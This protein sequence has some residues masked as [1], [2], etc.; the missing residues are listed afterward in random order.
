MATTAGRVITFL[1]ILLMTGL[2]ACGSSPATGTGGVVGAVETISY[3]TAVAGNATGTAEASRAIATGTAEAS[4]VYATGTAVMTT[5]TAAAASTATA[6]ANVSAT[7]VMATETAVAPTR[8]E[9]TRIAVVKA[10]R[11]NIQTGML[12]DSAEA[13]AELNAQ[14]LAHNQALIALDLERRAAEQRYE[15][16]KHYVS[17]V[18]GGLV[19]LVLVIIVSLVVGTWIMA[20]AADRKA[21]RDL[22]R[23]GLL[24]DGQRSAPA[25]SDDNT[26]EGALS[27]A[28]PASAN[29]GQITV[30]ESHDLLRGRR[31]NW[32]MFTEWRERYHIPLGAG[33]DGPVTLNVLESPH[34]AIVGSSR[35]GKSTGG[36]LTVGAWHLSHG[37]H[38]L[39]LNERAS[40]FRPFYTHPNAVHLRAYSLDARMALAQ[41]AVEAMLREME[42]R[43]NVL[44]RAGFNTWHQIVESG[45]LARNPEFGGEHGG[46]VIVIDEF[47]SMMAASST[48]T[49]DAFMTALVHLTAEAGKFDISAVV[50]ATDP[51]REALGRYGYTAMQQ[52]ARMVFGFHGDGPSLSILGNKSAVNLPVGHFI[53]ESE[54]GRPQAGVAFRPSGDD[55]A[56][57]LRRWPVGYRPTPGCL[58]P[59]LTATADTP[60]PRS[61]EPDEF[62]RAAGL[63]YTRGVVEDARLVMQYADSALQTR[64]AIARKLAADGH[65]GWGSSGENVRRVELAL[66]YLSRARNV[67]WAADILKEAP[68]SSLGVAGREQAVVLDFAGAAAD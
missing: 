62:A 19:V 11:D 3:A 55:L 10:E 1:S 26:I 45:E 22:L 44:H 13:Q 64:T 38:V 23:R 33:V 14:A 42:R 30:L 48:A 36:L 50:A 2:A 46:L 21:R 43:D 7:A 24:T 51:R 17:L 29:R 59:L 39:F 41:G 40:N 65:V 25:Q 27:E 58:A 20:W 54:S 56:A 66:E 52:M 35:M 5:A 63:G 49:R 8:A 47:L 57:M 67:V 15:R 12:E 18:L 32:Q 61:A 60:P 37:A 16:I 28:R 31:A 4:R 9:E 68:G 6:Q 34:L 53:L